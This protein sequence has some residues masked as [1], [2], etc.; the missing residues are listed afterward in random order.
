[1]H[2]VRPKTKRGVEGSN[3]GTARHA[4]HAGRL[5]VPPLDGQVGLPRGAARAGRVERAGGAAGA[6]RLHAAGLQPARGE[7]VGQVGRVELGEAEPTRCHPLLARAQAPRPLPHV[8]QQA[9]LLD[10]QRHRAEC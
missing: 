7:Q 8:H 4:G 2:K 9:G 3:V 5:P 10:C 6:A 1:M